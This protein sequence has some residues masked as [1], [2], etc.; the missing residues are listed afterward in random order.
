MANRPIIPK[1]QYDTFVGPL[2]EEYSSEEAKHMLRFYR[3]DAEAIA[4]RALYGLKKANAS[5]AESESEKRDELTGLLNRKYFYRHAN[6]ILNSLNVDEQRMGRPNNALIVHADGKGVKLWNDTMGHD[7]GDILL[8]NIAD[9][10]KQ[11]VRAGDSPGRLGGD[12]FGL[13][14]P[15]ST[16]LASPLEVQSGFN[17]RLLELVAAAEER[18]EIAGLKWCSTFFEPGLDIAEHL[19][20]ADPSPGVNA[21][22]IMEYPSSDILP[23]REVA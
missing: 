22:R 23:S 4:L 8:K 6:S 12:E 15:F 13:I 20:K 19:A 21:G 2:P 17:Q 5:I 3:E 10:F 7:R 16:S 1:I 11:L 18:G 14:L 9:I